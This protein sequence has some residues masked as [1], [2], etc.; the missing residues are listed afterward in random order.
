MAK[1]YTIW[2]YTSEIIIEILKSIQTNPMII[3]AFVCIALAVFAIKKVKSVL[4]I[5]IALLFTGYGQFLAVGLKEI[6]DVIR[7][8]V[9]LY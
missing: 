7:N 4:W 2:N 8:I 6:I 9:S 3:W 1:L 5:A